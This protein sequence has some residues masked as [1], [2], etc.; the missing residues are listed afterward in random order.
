M[1]EFRECETF[2][3]VNKTLP[4]SLCTCVGVGTSENVGR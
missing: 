1:C 3:R 2:R 4:G